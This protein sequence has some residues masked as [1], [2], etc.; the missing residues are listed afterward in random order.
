MTTPIAPAPFI[1]F[2][3]LGGIKGDKAIK[4]HQATFQSLRIA[5]RVIEIA[6]ARWKTLYRL[7]LTTM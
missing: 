7:R 4:R 1:P 2:K 3:Y 6:V 5:L